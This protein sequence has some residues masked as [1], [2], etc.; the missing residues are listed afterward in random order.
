MPGRDKIGSAHEKSHSRTNME[1]VSGARCLWRLRECGFG[2]W[3]ATAS[4]R[5]PWTK[6]LKENNDAYEGFSFCTHIRRRIARWLRCY[7][8]LICIAKW[9]AM[10]YF[11]QNKDDGVA[12]ALGRQMHGRRRC[13]LVMDRR[14]VAD[15]MLFNWSFIGST[16]LHK[17]WGDKMK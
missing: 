15:K 14:S 16:N 2:S 13:T 17:W 8:L 10:V 1:I 11:L 9:K 5:H 4:V 3:H 6:V 7:T 12:V